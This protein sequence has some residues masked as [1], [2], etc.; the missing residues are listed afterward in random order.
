MNKVIAKNGARHDAE[1]LFADLQEYTRLAIKSA[2]TGII[3]SYG[4][5]AI[6]TS[7]GL[8]IETDNSLLVSYTAPPPGD[9]GFGYVTIS[10]GFAITEAIE[11]MEVTVPQTK[12]VPDN[13][14]HT[15]YISPVVQNTE[16][17]A[18][19]NGF[20]YTPGT[21][22]TPT[23]Q[24]DSYEFLWDT[25]P[26]GIPL[27]DINIAAGGST[28]IVVDRRSEHLVKINTHEVNSALDA[29][30]INSGVLLRPFGGTGTNM[31]NYGG[32]IL[33]TG[34]YVVVQDVNHNISSRALIANDLPNLDASKIS[35]GTFDIARIP[36]VPGSYINNI[37]S[38]A[39]FG[40]KE[41]VAL[42]LRS[43]PLLQQP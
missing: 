28:A 20:N 5:V 43:A 33:T 3:S 18:V 14:L 40:Y 1:K 10:P 23:R 21:N 36:G 35:T 27:A 42:L 8:I 6:T 25:A 9:S 41:Y 13:S 22:T 26:L 34:R 19:V 37:L 29:S 24:L 7:S 15:L 16:Y 2:L 32:N 4:V 17:T 11:F 12:M 38:T 39:G 30:S 31:D